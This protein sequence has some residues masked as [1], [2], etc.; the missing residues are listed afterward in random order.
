LISGR[1]SFVICGLLQITTKFGSCRQYVKKQPNFFQIN[2]ST[3]FF[4]D[5]CEGKKKFTGE[6]TDERIILNSNFKK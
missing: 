4:N 6:N 2:T 5:M 1:K 3:T